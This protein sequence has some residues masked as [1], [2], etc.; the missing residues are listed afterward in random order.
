MPLS[1]VLEWITELTA[2]TISALSSMMAGVLP[3]PT[4]MAGLP[5]EYA[6]FTMP[7]PPVAK[8]TSARRMTMLVSSK[9]GTSI[10]TNRPSGAPAATAAFKTTFIAAMV[11]FL[12]RGCGQIT[13][14]LRVF[15]ASSPLKIAVDVGL[16][17]GI[18]AASTPKGSAM[19]CVPPA[20]S[21]AITPQVFVSLYAL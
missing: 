16:V 1:K 3:A 17:V 18:T 21:S 9:P 8:I 4:P 14:P 13:M 19:V 6:D 2:V 20:L 15:K 7:G 10:H 11:Q 12:A 5:L